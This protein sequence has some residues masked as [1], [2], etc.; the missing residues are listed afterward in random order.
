MTPNFD[1]YGP[2]YARFDSELATEL[3]RE[4]YGEDMGQQGWRSSAEQAEIADLLRLGPDRHILDVAC[5]AGGPSLALVE[6]T[7]CRLTGLDAEPA[8]IARAQA[9]TAQRGLGDRATFA[10]VDCGGPLPYPDG[11][12]DAVLC[13]DAICHLPDRLATLSEWARLLRR[14]GRLLFSDP[15]VVTGAVAKSALDIRAAAGFFLFVPPGINEEAIKAADLNLLRC[16]DRTRACAE[17]AARWHAARARR[18]AV[19]QL[20]EGAAWFEQRQRFLATTAELASSGRLS[21]FLYV[22][23]KSAA[24]A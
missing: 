14:G 9:K 17:I 13:I 8:G 24:P 20:D 1:F 2:Q 4:V 11:A 19:L 15:V 7:S 21:R 18:A 22:A 23:E 10:V 12:F 3:R 6:R 5:G 16:E